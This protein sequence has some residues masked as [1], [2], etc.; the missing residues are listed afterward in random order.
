MNREI[1]DN[2]KSF[3]I[4]K[5]WES[6]SA[7]NPDFNRIN[8][9]CD[10]LDTFF[11]NSNSK[12]SW[13]YKILTSKNISSFF[14]LLEITESLNYY[15]NLTE[16]EKKA[17]R[18]YKKNNSINTDELENIL[19]E[20][21]INFKLSKQG[22]DP[23][24]TD[25]YTTENGIEKPLDSSFYFNNKKYLVECTKLYSQNFNLLS[26]LAKYIV[27]SF[28]KR[29]TN[30]NISADEMFC[31]YI[32]IKANRNLEKFIHQAEK[33]F[34]DL[35]KNYFHSFNDKKKDLIQLPKPIDN[36]DYELKIEPNFEN[37]YENKY[38]TKLSK[39]DH[40]VKFQMKVENFETNKITANIHFKT[41][42]KDITNFICEKIKRK[43]SQHKSAKENKII[44][45]EIENTEYLDKYTNLIP[46]TIE[47]I[48]NEEEKFKELVN[49]NKNKNISIVLLLKTI[50][51]SELK[52]DMILISSSEF[53]KELK[54]KLINL[55][56]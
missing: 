52:Y 8:E 20:I 55:L 26:K 28:R 47:N 40:Y 33:D 25:S 39:F 24:C 45:I 16:K 49:K 51:Q 37:K 9:V 56:N 12:N 10:C 35:F 29:G 34:Q 42:Y 27:E 6:G 48:K 3:I 38:P 4:Q 30:Q 41:T 54:G 31:G 7:N 23:C 2:W 46:L 13:I 32:A 11:S 17:F 53:D 19:F 14:Q 21:F 22:L 50:T 43:I 15:N 1:I 5:K 36:K 18:L 44:F